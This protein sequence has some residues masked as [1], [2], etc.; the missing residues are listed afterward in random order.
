VSP[1]VAYKKHTL[2]AKINKLKVKG[3]KKIFQADAA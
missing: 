2:L 3:W 1:F